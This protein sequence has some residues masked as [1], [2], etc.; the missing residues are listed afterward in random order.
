M[1]IRQQG[2]SLRTIWSKERTENDEHKHS[3][4]EMGYQKLPQGYYRIVFEAISTKKGGGVN[5]A[6]DD[7][8]IGPCKRGMDLES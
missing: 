8:N 2:T 4:W 5:V 7:I 6:M 1:R 3:E